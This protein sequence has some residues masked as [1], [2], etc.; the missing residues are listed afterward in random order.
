MQNVFTMEHPTPSPALLTLQHVL[1]N[2]A[3]HVT[4]VLVYIHNPQEAPVWGIIHSVDLY[5]Q[6]KLVKKMAQTN[7]VLKTSV[8]NLI[9]LH[10]TQTVLWLITVVAMVRIAQRNCSIPTPYYHNHLQLYYYK[11]L[12]LYCSLLPWQHH[13]C[14]LLPLQELMRTV[15][16]RSGSSVQSQ[17]IR[18]KMLC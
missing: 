9:F 3:L 10:Q 1:L 13:L 17:Q 16:R 18:T 11:H 14:Q 8:R 2:S 5:Q 4:I 6:I 7:N 15:S 12:Q